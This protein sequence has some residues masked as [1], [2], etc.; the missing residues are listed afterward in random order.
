LKILLDHNLDRRLK[1]YLT[2]YETATTQEQNW[3]D[4]LNGELLTL[5]EV[6]GFEVLL[7]ADANI[8]NQQNLSNRQISILVLRAFNNRL[9]THIEMIEEIH[10]ALAEIQSGEIVEIFHKDLTEKL[11]EPD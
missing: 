4:A 11:K 3:A 10:E 9:A 5:A 2:E 6:N 8:K 1:N 7:T